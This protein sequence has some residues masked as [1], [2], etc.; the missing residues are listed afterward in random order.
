MLGTMWGMYV[1]AE[2]YKA[3]GDPPSTAAPSNPS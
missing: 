2:R 1:A 3:S